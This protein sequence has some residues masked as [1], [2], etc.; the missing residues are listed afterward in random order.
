MI[1]NVRPRSRHFPV[2]NIPAIYLIPKNLAGRLVAG[3]LVAGELV[4]GELVAGR[5][6]AGELVDGIRDAAH[7]TT[8]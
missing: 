1:A 4:A 6:V 5:L 3:R 8:R 2:L 7:S